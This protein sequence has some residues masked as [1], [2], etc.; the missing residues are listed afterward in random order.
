LLAGLRQLLQPAFTA[1]EIFHIE[2]DEALVLV[3]ELGMANLALGVIGV[4]SLWFPAFVLP[5]AI[6]AAIFYGAAG[7]Q[8]ITAKARSRN[9]T[10]AMLSDLFLFAVLAAY[11]GLVALHL[12]V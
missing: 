7:V 9:E 10:I 8:H 12:T 2:G 5:V 6:A 3:R 11:V 1:R 4:L